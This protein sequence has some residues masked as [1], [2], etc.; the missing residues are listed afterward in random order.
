MSIRK[1]RLSFRSFIVAAIS[2]S[3]LSVMATETL[4][5][6]SPALAGASVLPTSATDP[7]FCHD[8]GQSVG[9]SFAGVDACNGA[10]ATTNVN[11]YFQGSNGSV[12]R[13]DSD[14]FQC[15]ELVTRYLYAVKGWGVLEQNGAN[16]VSNYGSTY[17]VTP[18]VNGAG[19]APQVGDVIS[20]SVEPNFTDGGGAYP[21]HVAIVVATSATSI[22][23][24]SENFNG[25]AGT[26]V[27]GLSGST[28]EP[29]KNWP[30][31]E[32]YDSGG[33][34]VPTPYVEWL[35]VSTANPEI[36]YQ[37]A[38][39]S[40][41]TAG[42]AGSSNLNLG[43]MKGTSPSIAALP[44]GG[45]E[46]AFQANTGSLYSVGADGAPSVGSWNLGMM[47][48]TSPSIAALPSGGY[49]IAFQANTG[50]LYSVGADGA[51]SVGSWNAGMMKGTSP[52][53]A[54][55][56]SGGYEIAYQGA[57][58]SLSTAGSAGSSN[59]NLGMM[60]GT[61]PS[62]AA[63]PSGGYEIAF[64]AN[65]GSLYSVGADGAPS[66]GSWNLG[67]MKGTSPSIGALP[68]GGYEIA[69][70]ANT[71]SLYSVGADGA[72]SV[73]SWNAGL[74][75]GTSPSIAALPSGGYEIAFQ[76]NTGSLYSVGADGA[77]SVGSLNL[78]M[79]K[80]TSPSIAG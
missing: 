25:A 57:T 40:L 60:K 37:G 19:A 69:F 66:V 70:Q 58:G 65:T 78:G 10:A 72:P 71:G 36:A 68:S 14:G 46:I 12:V 27:L 33:Q 54:A 4:A 39:G 77:P 61:S 32:T 67:M 31:F 35:P 2:L 51:P 26:T 48:G 76:A 62:I 7:N 47:K 38:T 24:L 9:G 13:S 18:I 45:Y 53:I 28:V 56:P 75:K 23:I 22:T 6:V 21:G 55:L 59:L 30:G 64:Q 8:Y 49:E 80:G 63:L 3:A 41:S 34:L 29:N 42:S 79:M 17:G 74:M 44:S 11:I 73:G 1:Q 20:F 15:V 52:S 16:V 5:S 43:M 50:S